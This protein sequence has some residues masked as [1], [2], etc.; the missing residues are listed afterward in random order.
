[1]INI[2]QLLVET[3]ALSLSHSL[4]IF[5]CD[6]YM[7]TVDRYL[8]IFNPFNFCRLLD[9]FVSLFVSDGC[10]FEGRFLGELTKQVF[11]DLTASKYQVHHSSFFIVR[12]NILASFALCRGFNFYSIYEVYSQLFVCAF[13]NFYDIDSL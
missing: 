12:Y 1:M 11:S 9:F 13:S 7:N 2:F 4:S 3:L 8:D 10:L 5:V 6:I